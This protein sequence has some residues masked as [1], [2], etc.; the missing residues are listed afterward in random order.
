[1][2]LAAN[3]LFAHSDLCTIVI[4]P[5]RSQ[6]TEAFQREIAS[7]EGIQYTASFKGSHSFPQNNII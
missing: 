4:Q 3:G 1:M 2:C 7:C 5:S 6:D